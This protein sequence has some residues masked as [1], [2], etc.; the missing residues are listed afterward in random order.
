MPLH[1]DFYSQNEILLEFDVKLVREFVIIINN[2]RMQPAKRI[3]YN[4]TSD[5]FDLWTKFC[6]IGSKCILFLVQSKDSKQ[7]KQPEI[8]A[9]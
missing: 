5:H 4:C 3:R 9:G 6:R 7:N 1:D 8:S 2:E